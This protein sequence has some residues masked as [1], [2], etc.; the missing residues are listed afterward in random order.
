MAFWHKWF[1]PKPFNDGYLPE[2]DGHEIYFREFGNPQGE[3]ILTFHGG[4][5]FW[6]RSEKARDFDL[7]KYR[8]IQFDQRGCGKSKPTGKLENNTTQDNI[9]DAVR[10]L[11]YLK[12]NGKII[13]FGG[14]WGSTMA[15]MFAERYP[16]LVKCMILSKI[17]LANDD[18]RKWELKDSAVFYPDILEAI[19]GDLSDNDLI[20]EY[21]LKLINSDDV[22]QQAKAASLYGSLETFLGCLNPQIKMHTP[23]EKE[24]AMLRVY[25]HYAARRFMMKNDELIEN[26]AKIKHIP[27]LIVHN[28]LDFICP[29][30]NAYRLHK[31]LPMSK[32]IFVPDKG[33]SSKMLSD[34]IIKEMNEFLLKYGDK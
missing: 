20:P 18:C 19:R 13:L 33:H 24:L 7:K 31:A 5:G 34:V 17:F 11:S 22:S 27:S 8:V 6:S 25:I 32:L 26:A 9:E 21:Y 12:I 23:D 3:V 1:V 15:L 30:V 29:P 2:L 10:L 14:S 16:D 28:R 4:P